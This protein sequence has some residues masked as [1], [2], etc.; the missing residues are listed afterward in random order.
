MNKTGT[1][2]ALSIDWNAADAGYSALTSP[3]MAAYLAANAGKGR[4][5][6]QTAKPFLLSDPVLHLKAKRFRVWPNTPRW[7]EVQCRTVDRFMKSSPCRIGQSVKI[8]LKCKSNERVA[9][10]GVYVW[11]LIS[12]QVTKEQHVAFVE[13]LKRTM[14]DHPIICH[15]EEVDWFHLKAVFFSTQ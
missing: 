15:N 14:G 2:L 4:N 5:L 8:F 3:K 9:G 7:S 10:F 11:M 6:I 13:E 1:S 12:G